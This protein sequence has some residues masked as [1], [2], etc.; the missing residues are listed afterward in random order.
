MPIP[1]IKIHS[2]DRSMQTIN[3]DN[4]LAVQVVAESA[5][6][7]VTLTNISGTT[8]AAGQTQLVAAPGAGLQIIV[9]AFVIQNE[10]ASATTMRLEA[11]AAAHWRVLAQNQG[12]GLS[13]QFEIG[14]EWELPAN[15]AL[16][17]WLSGANSCGYSIA[18]YVA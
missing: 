17:L 15:T 11:G 8:A 5:A 4:P 16:N 9:N 12:D 13:G 6:A 1:T 10:S 7:N 3:A 2:A 18:Y 14:R